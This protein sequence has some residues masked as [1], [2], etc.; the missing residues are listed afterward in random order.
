MVLER[1]QFAPISS[2]I[3]S[4]TL[5]ASERL[6]VAISFG[7]E[8]VILP[9]RW[10]STTQSKSCSTSPGYFDMVT[11]D[12]IKLVEKVMDYIKANI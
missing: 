3:I 8:D 6:F 1:R 11:A 2:K 7:N 12:S 9:I 4:E 5:N 10:K